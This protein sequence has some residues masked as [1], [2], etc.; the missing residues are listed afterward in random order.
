MGSA[1]VTVL[2]P[3]SV[4]D[5]QLHK[6]IVHRKKMNATMRVDNFPERKS[7]RNGN[8]LSLVFSAI[9]FVCTAFFHVCFDIE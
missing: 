3:R 5:G 6:V 4:S 2:E 7:W 8:E 9:H 1:D